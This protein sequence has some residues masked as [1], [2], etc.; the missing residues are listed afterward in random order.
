M[1]MKLMKLT[2]FEYTGKGETIYLNPASVI[3]I[4]AGRE[5]V[6]ITYPYNENSYYH[7]MGTVEEV[8]RVWEEAINTETCG[9]LESGRKTDD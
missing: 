2:S 6:Y 7:V 8:A 4:E 1:K 5:G 9:N 3:G